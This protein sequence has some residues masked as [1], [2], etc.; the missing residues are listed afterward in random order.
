AIG[1]GALEDGDIDME[2]GAH[3]HREQ[4]GAEE[5]PGQTIDGFVAQQEAAPDADDEIEHVAA[6]AYDEVE[7]TGHGR[8]G[9]SEGIGHAGDVFDGSARTALES[10]G[11]EGEEKED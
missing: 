11:D 4:G 2:Q 1:F 3:G 9:F 6:A 10:V 8:A 7:D 5:A